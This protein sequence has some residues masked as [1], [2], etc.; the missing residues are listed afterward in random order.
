MKAF[1]AETKE[2][3]YTLI[4]TCIL[5]FLI[6]TFLFSPVIVEGQSM[7]PNLHEGDR[8]FVNKI[9][10]YV[11]EIERYDVV[12]FKNKK[13]KHYIKRVIGMPGD[14]VEFIDGK[15][16]INDQLL[17]ENYI[18]GPEQHRNYSVQSLYGIERIPKDCY[19]VL[20][21]N[22]NNSMDSRKRAIGLIHKN[23][24]LGSAN[25]IVWPIS[26]VNEVRPS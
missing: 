2:W 4:A 1:F 15:L 26:R 25:V 23:Q 17:E 9:G 11:G 21:D 3:I 22:R 8:L 20:G 13:N 7:L 16:Y 19:F 6:R 5:I 18:L 14:K 24:I 10:M 12:V